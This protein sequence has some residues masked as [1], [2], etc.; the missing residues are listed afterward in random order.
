M[1]LR[2]R[3]S[4]RAAAVNP[5]PILA[6][7]FLPCRHIK[8]SCR[9]TTPNLAD[10]CTR[11]IADLKEVATDPTGVFLGIRVNDDD[12]SAEAADNAIP[13]GN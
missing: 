12:K 10:V 7:L 6:C 5:F 3:K 4:F 1:G 8:P 13:S 9:F 2:F 11:W